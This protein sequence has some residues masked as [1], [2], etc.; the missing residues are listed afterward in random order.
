MTT[1]GDQV[2]MLGGVPV[3]PV[4]SV[5]AGIG[6]WGDQYFVNFTTGHDDNDGDKPTFAFKTL[7]AAYDAATTNKNDIIWVAGEGA[8][9]ED[10][11]ITWSKNKVHVVGCGGFGAT[12]QSP[13]IIFSA[14]G[15]TSVSAANLKV[16][17]WA[18]TFT[19]IRVNSWGTDDTNVCALW[20]AGEATVYTNCQFNKFTDLDQTTVADVEARGDSTTWRNVK[21]GADTLLQTV[22]RPTLRIKGTGGNAR[23]KNNYFEDCYFVC[24]SSDADKAFILVHDTNS[25]AFSNVWVRPIFLAAVITSTSAITLDNAVDS[26]SGLVEGNLLFVNPSCNTTALCATVTDKVQVVGPLTHVNAG[27]P[28]TPA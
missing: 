24:Q 19:N 8:V 12:D 10:A 15:I 14:T 16:T 4:G 3:G 2:Y 21:F 5:L 23:M 25:L 7:G 20:D 27:A 17:G 9:E 6:M 22:A 11:M 28:Q 1:F 26:V 13:R 18:N